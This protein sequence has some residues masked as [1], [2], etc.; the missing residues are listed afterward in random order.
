[1]GGVELDAGVVDQDVEAAEGGCDVGDG[2]A[3]GGFGGHV[4][5][6]R[7]GGVPGLGECGGGGFAG[8]QRARADYHV[9][10]VLGGE[11]RGGGEADAGVGAGDE[12]DGLGWGGHCCVFVGG[13]V[14]W[15][16]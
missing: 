15:C 13:S 12:G 1:M 8:G 11:G 14:V 10:A 5:L 7:G 6:Q 4:E 2:G 3:D 9:V 16:I